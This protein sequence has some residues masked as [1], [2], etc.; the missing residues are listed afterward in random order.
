[1]ISASAILSLVKLK[2]WSSYICYRRCTNL[3]LIQKQ[4]YNWT[5][6][7]VL[8]IASVR[9]SISWNNFKCSSRVEKLTVN[10]LF[11]QTWLE[12]LINKDYSH[13]SLLFM[14]FISI[15]GSNSF[16]SPRSRVKVRVCSIPDLK[17]METSYRL[18][19]KMYMYSRT[20]PFLLHFGFQGMLSRLKNYIYDWLFHYQVLVT[21]RFP[22][23]YVM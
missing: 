19:D 2:Q 9:Q 1:M 3:K 7:A 8:K 5:S 4:I 11:L 13:G 12:K 20:L 22:H 6:S 15:T 10:G 18:A 23:Q 16:F 21:G 17:Y 14:G